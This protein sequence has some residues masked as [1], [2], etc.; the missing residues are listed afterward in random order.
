MGGFRDHLDY[1]IVI[2]EISKI[3]LLGEATAL[4]NLGGMII[5][6]MK[7]WVIEVTEDLNM[8]IFLAHHV[9]RFTEFLKAVKII[10]MGSVVSC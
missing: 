9:D 5:I 8:S 6:P 7:L 3:I 4:L 1:V 2:K 10:F